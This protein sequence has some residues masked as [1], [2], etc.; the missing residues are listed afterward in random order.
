VNVVAFS[1]DKMD[2]VIR[3]LKPVLGS[4]ADAIASDHGLQTG[5]TRTTTNDDWACTD[6]MTLE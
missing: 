5:C 6:A 3:A 2:A 1:P 4:G